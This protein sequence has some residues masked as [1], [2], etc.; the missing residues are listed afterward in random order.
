MDSS[1]FLFELTGSPR[2]VFNYYT[3]GH[4]ATVEGAC[5]VSNSVTYNGANNRLRLEYS[6][7]AF[8]NSS[9]CLKTAHPVH[10]GYN[11]VYDYDTFRVDLD[12]HACLI[13]VAVSRKLLHIHDLTMIPNTTEHIRTGETTSIEIDKFFDDRYGNISP[14]LCFELDTDATTGEHNEAVL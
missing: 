14:V 13:G 6:Y 12:L 8:R 2:D 10:L 11:P 7:S 1:N 3:I 5:D 4:M 9:L